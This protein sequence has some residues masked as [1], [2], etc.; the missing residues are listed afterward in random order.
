MTKN[1][2]QAHEKQAIQVM[3]RLLSQDCRIKQWCEELRQ[4][5]AHPFDAQTWCLTGH[6]VL[7]EAED[8]DLVRGTM[9]HIAEESRMQLHWVSPAN[10][11]ENF[12]Q[13]LAA[14]PPDIP[15]IVYMEPGAW[16]GSS[17]VPATDN[18]ASDQQRGAVL[19]EQLSLFLR[20]QA[21]RRPIVFVSTAPSFNKLDVSL[22]SVNHFDRRIRFPDLSPEIHAQWFL[23]EMEGQ[24]L[25]MS[26]TQDTR[27]L[28]ALLRY[29]Y[30]DQRRRGLMQQAMRR[31][32]WR[33]RRPLE[34]ADLV[35]FTV[36]GTSEVDSAANQEASL[37]R[38]AVHEAGHALIT[39]IDSK[40]QVPSAYCSVL[41]HTDSQGVVVSPFDSYERLSDDLSYYDISH[42]I[43]V[44][45]GGRAAEHLL[46][47]PAQVSAEGASSDLEQATR[48]ASSMMGAWGL[49]NDLTSDE[50]ASANLA[51]VV[52]VISASEARHVEHLTRQFLQQQ[53]RKTLEILRT[54]RTYLEGI[55]A[56]LVQKKVLLETDF[57]ILRMSAGAEPAIPMALL[58]R[59][60][61]K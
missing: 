32:A 33:E 53:F 38:H 56:A 20:E 19:R 8:E 47:G 26:I 10:M 54:H 9:D 28:G 42:K 59:N 60:C 44:W 35:R 52:D 13:W 18:D 40:D 49:A 50:T 27:K 5:C 15:S 1:Q 3:W 6:A 22:R 17:E 25:A 7:V 14:L 11:N 61:S 31:L 2:V 12:A 29:E 37:Y 57:T 16:L 39:H 45:L 55:V 4:V 48:L 41:K 30:P 51:V 43:R 23:S 21:P 46:L 36:Y 58:L 24:A 34:F